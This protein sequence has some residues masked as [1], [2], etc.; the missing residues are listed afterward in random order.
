MHTEYDKNSNKYIKTDGKTALM[1]F[2]IIYI[3]QRVNI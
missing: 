3:N 1:F 2:K